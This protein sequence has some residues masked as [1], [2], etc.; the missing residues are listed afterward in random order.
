MSSETLESKVDDYID[1]IKYDNY[2]ENQERNIMANKKTLEYNDVWKTLRA[3]DCSRV[4]ENK[5]GLDYIAW[6]DAWSLLMG[7]FPEATYVFDEPIFYGME[8]KR[9][10]EVTCTIYIGDL[11]RTWSLPVMTASMPMK[12]I[13]EPS[14]RDINDAK[15]RCFVKVMGMFGLG[16]H[17]W[18]KREKPASTLTL[19]DERPF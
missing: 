12:S 14:S 10:C 15:A 9:T 13:I 6:A 5:M 1:Q 3:V 4:I 17:L 8:G 16:L 19:N 2:L 7:E 18:E 11:Q